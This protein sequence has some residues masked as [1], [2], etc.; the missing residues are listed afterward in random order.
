MENEQICKCGEIMENLGNVSNMT[1]TSNPPQ[2]DEV[3]VCHK[4]KTKKTVRVHAQLPPDDSYLD[5]YTEL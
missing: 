3:Y 4:C 5:N 2:W 1:Y